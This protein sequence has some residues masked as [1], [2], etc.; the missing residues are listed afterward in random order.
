MAVPL[1]LWLKDEGGADI[2][3]SSEVFGRE[4]SI[5]VLS[6]THG[7]HSPTD[8]NTG[9]LIGARSHRPLTIE[10]EI[11]RS[12][13]LL[14]RAVAR[15]ATLQSGELRFYRATDAG[16]EEAYFT[17]SM[18]NVK[19]VGVSPKVLNIREVESQHRNHFEIVEFRYEE[20]AWTYADG[21]MIF[22][23]AWSYI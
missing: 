14:Y 5:E 4:G 1:H 20:I 10:K 7:V 2:L 8:S 19:V 23:D 17:V 13:A 9:K 6:L 22:K 21:N 18:K 11:D 12:S 16:R 3:G 15:G